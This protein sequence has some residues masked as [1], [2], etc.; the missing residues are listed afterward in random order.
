MSKADRLNARAW[1]GKPGHYEVWYI[2][3]NHGDRGFW[4][5]TTLRSPI[6]GPPEGALWFVE[7]VPGRS[8]RAWKDPIPPPDGPRL[9]GRAGEAE[10][11]LSIRSDG[12][13]LRP[14]P[15]T[16]RSFVGTKFV[17][18]HWD[19]RI[20]GT[21]RVGENEYRLDGA[22]GTQSHLWGRGYGQGWAWAHAHF[23]AGAFEGLAGKKP[24]L[25][26]LYARVGR[27]RWPMNTLLTS[28]RNRS[29]RAPSP[30]G[31]R[32]SGTTHNREIAGEIS[33]DPRHLAGVTYTGPAGE[34]IYCYNT[35]IATFSGELRTRSLFGAPWH[36]AAKVSG[37]AHF[38]I[39]GRDPIPDLPILL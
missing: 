35:E 15:A 25:I 19:A 8:P 24:A 13:I 34:K 22:R 18:P 1:N 11:D 6:D 12:S 39:A 4:I 5:R 3:L 10:W 31:W 33:C 7:F 27:K 9:R 37:P 38:E 32:F 16:L 28:V 26:S 17:T 21:I 2:T 29:V 20:S 23:D 30:Q 14:I 36:V